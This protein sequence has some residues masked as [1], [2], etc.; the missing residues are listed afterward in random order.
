M[1]IVLRTFI[2]L[3]INQ[4]NSQYENIKNQQDKLRNNLDPESERKYEIYNMCYNGD[5]NK[6]SQQLCDSYL[7]AIKNDHKIFKL[8]Y[9]EKNNRKSHKWYCDFY[10]KP[11]QQY[12]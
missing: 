4:L 10:C 3:R 9:Q 2:N 12:Y 6:T 11:N 5:L 1:S 8:I 7:E